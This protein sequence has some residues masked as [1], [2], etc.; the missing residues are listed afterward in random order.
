M[1]VETADYITELDKNL[2]RGADSISEGDIHLRTIKDVL[3]RSFP[4]VDSPVNGIHTSATEPT[5]HSPGTVWFDTST[6]LVKMRDKAD[7]VWLNM[8]HGEANGLGS[9]LRVTWHNLGVASGRW[10][11]WVELFPP[12][13]VTS[14]SATSSFI[15]ELTGTVSVAGYGRNQLFYMRFRDITN[16]VYIGGEEGFR[17]GGFLHSDDVDN[18]ESVSGLSSRILSDHLSGSHMVVLEGKSNNFD[19][20]SGTDIDNCVVS[21]TEIE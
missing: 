11:D 16:D 2:P 1:A 14:L 19:L 13:E 20:E 6:G 5:L 17:V 4:N 18:F 8:A 3:K 21:I 12:F 10:D 9:T 15:Y 7:T